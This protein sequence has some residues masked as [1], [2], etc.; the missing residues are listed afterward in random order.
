MYLLR[1]LLLALVL[2]PPA[3]RVPD[4][5]LPDLDGRE[6]RLSSVMGES[7]T[8][9]DFWATWCGPC[10]K[11]IPSLVAISDSLSDQGVRVVGVNVDSPRNL[12]KVAPYA[13]SLGVDYPI[14]LDTNSEVM[15]DL[16]VQAM[17]TLL[18]ID[19]KRNIVYV[20]EGFRPGDEDVVRREIEELLKDH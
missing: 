4:F 14:L 6:T 2:I 19:A 7:L 17:P 3:D 1:S 15:A 20:H 16:N 10:V 12:S 18:V 9:I 13:R 11:S 8:L 5:S